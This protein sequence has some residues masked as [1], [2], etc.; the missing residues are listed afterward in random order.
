MKTDTVLTVTRRVV[1]SV[2]A[3]HA[4]MLL[5]L[6]LMAS[7]ASAET[8]RLA[9]SRTP[10]SLPLYIAQHHGYF[11]AEGLQVKFN[12]C[13]GG[14][15][16]LRMVL[17]G[18]ADVATSSDLP[19]VMNS[20][21][22]AD[23]A[24]IG[25]FTKSSEDV[26]LVT[27]PHANIQS[28]QQLAGKRIGVTKGS[29]GEY[30]LELFLLTAGVDPQTLTIVNLQPE[31]LVPALQADNVD[32]ISAWQPYG[33]QAVQGPAKG[34]VLPGGNAYIQTFNL[35][36]HRKLVGVRD[37]TLTKLLRAVERAE[38]FIQ[39]QPTQAK[40]IMRRLLAPDQEFVDAVWPGMHY[41]LGLDQALLATME[42]EARWA[43]REGHANGTVNP[44]FLKL[45]HAGPLRS[46]KP[47]AVAALR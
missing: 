25:T 32:A 1:S 26:K 18:Q 22:S 31:E 44:N 35:V 37:A 3:W 27:S 39:E 23:Y 12:E 41:R 43:R 11:A 13:L 34:R 19:I 46:I 2:R 20:F 28:P 8:L 15:R 29:A 5:G 21:S 42:G 47:D 24:V 36:S 16:C 45:V 10:L 4:S 14:H 40:N 33:Y 30:F 7:Q 6:A 38:R 9:V 17:D